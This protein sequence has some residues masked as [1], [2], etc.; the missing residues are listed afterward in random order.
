MEET[1]PSDKARKPASG[2]ANILVDYGP[3][4]VFFL[5]YRWYKPDSED[6]VA[7]VFAV[8]RGTGAFI[9]AAIAALLYSKFR[10]GKVSPMLWISTALI[11]G[12]GGLTIFLADPFWIQIKPTVIYLFFGVALL[13]AWLRGKALLQWAL[14]S[15]FEGLSEEGWLKL[16]RNWAFFF[17]ALAALNESMRYFLSFEDWLAAKLWV[18]LPLSFIFTFAQLPMLLRHGLAAEAKGEEETTLPPT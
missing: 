16:S 6:M 2:W 13:I 12:F 10:L 5:V 3:I 14:E 11:A 1:G 15:A 17:F 9:V 8:I 18:F 7:E 4:L